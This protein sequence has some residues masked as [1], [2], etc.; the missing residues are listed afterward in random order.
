LKS[1][2]VGYSPFG[3]IPAAHY[4]GLFKLELDPVSITT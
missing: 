1:L 3:N 4:C 2:H